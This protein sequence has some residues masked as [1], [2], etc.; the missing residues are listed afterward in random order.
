MAYRDDAG[1]DRRARL[2]EALA[3]H[4]SG[5][6]RQA[7]ETEL[8]VADRARRVEARRHL[9]TVASARIASPCPE[10]WETMI[11]EGAV[12]AC[13]RCDQEV[14]DLGA[15]TLAQA[16]ALIRSRTGE[17]TCARLRRRADGTMMF[18]DCEVGAS[19][20]RARRIGVALGALAIAAAAAAS[21]AS[22]GGRSFHLPTLAESVPVTTYTEVSTHYVMGA[23]ESFATAPAAMP[24][25]PPPGAPG[26]IVT[27]PP[28]RSVR[29]R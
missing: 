6:E 14:F 16:D 22:M 19:G 8:A 27:S 25:S 9:P 13:S 18:R 23:L 7:L 29:D 1:L 24:D 17:R 11:G 3:K 12:R 26:Y 28:R 2:V 4:P 15:M 21:S 5:D 10:I 20:V